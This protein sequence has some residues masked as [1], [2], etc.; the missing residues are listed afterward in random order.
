MKRKLTL[1]NTTYHYQGG[2]RVTGTLTGV[3]GDLSGVTG[4]LTDVRGDLTDVWGD[5]SSVTGD[6]S[7]VWGYLTGVTGNLN[8]C[9]ITDED[10]TAGIDIEDLIEETE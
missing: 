1:K 3:T 5:L 6:L 9:G 7:G 10:R 8:D 4:D 2:K